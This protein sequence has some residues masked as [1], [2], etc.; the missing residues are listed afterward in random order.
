[1]AKLAP[2]QRLTAEDFKEQAGWIERLIVPINVYF[3]RTTSALNRAL[4]INENFAG[5]LR[6]V[7][8][9]GVFPLKL[10]WTVTARPTAV[11]VGQVERTDG[12]SFTLLTAVQLLWSYNQAGQ[13]Q[14]DGVVGITPTTTT[15]YNL[16]LVV[17]TT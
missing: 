12:T 2:V 10:S 17:L 9:D 3:E 6:T 1:M 16:R 14:I 11:L 8:I 15:K 5:E 13:L 4:T 7:T